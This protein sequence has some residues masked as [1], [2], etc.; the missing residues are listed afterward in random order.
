MILKKIHATIKA[1]VM[2]SIEI[3]LTNE[4]H[5]NEQKTF[6]ILRICLEELNKWRDRPFCYLVYG[7]DWV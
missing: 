2:K 3:H 7:F 5:I 6:L 1:K 4:V